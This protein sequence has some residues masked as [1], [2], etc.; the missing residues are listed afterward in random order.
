MTLFAARFRLE[1]KFN[2]Y[3]GIER[4]RKELKETRGRRTIE[5]GSNITA[6]VF[7]SNIDRS[8][9]TDLDHCDFQPL[10]FSVL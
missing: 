5:I 3:V 4:K 2:A 1:L 7:L 9:H 6:G 8:F 10:N